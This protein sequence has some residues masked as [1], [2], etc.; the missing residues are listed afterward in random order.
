MCMP[1]DCIYSSIRYEIFKVFQ[2]NF[3]IISHSSQMEFL[4]HD[5][6]HRNEAQMERKAK[7]VFKAKNILL[8]E[9]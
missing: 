3:I 5:D 2:V 1:L 6:V 9:D 8:S 7:T 4:I